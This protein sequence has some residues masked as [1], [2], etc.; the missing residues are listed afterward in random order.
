[1][2]TLTLLVSTK[3]AALDLAGAVAAASGGDNFPNDGHTLLYV[4]NQGAGG[5]TVTAD[6]IANKAYTIGTLVRALIGPFPKSDFDDV[7][8]KVQI[9]YSGV[10][11]VTVAAIR[12]L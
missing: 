4:S 11:T 2:A 10:T 1:M 12:A 8:G 6:S 5:I 7:D 9:T 3:N